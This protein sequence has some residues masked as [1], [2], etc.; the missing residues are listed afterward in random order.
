MSRRDRDKRNDRKERRD[1][2]KRSDLGASPS[3]V[4][5][6]PTTV[7]EA[8]RQ[9]R[10][11]QSKMNALFRAPSVPNYQKRVT[12]KIVDSRPIAPITINGQMFTPSTV[13][14]TPKREARP[15]T[16]LP[17]KKQEHDSSPSVRDDH[18]K[19][20]V[21]KKRPDKLTPRRA[22][23]GAAKKFVPWCK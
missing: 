19:R 5:R 9:E 10:V 15:K 13:V 1:E 17:Q 3:R 23:G 12:D 21:C 11:E 4:K 18:K 7:K 6:S 14:Q 2:R 20:D 22:G 16:P 8:A